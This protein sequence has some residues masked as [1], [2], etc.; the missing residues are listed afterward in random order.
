MKIPGLAKMNQ[1]RLRSKYKSW[2]GKSD[3]PGQQE[4]NIHEPGTFSDLA[5]KLNASTA[6]PK[7]EPK[8]EP[9]PVAVEPKPEAPSPTDATAVFMH[10]IE[11][12]KKAEERQRQ[13]R[14]FESLPPREQ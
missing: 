3:L 6:E 14:E 7:P 1:P 10:Q 5:N 4:L 8:P 13:Q 11:E 12:L 2:Q 9:A